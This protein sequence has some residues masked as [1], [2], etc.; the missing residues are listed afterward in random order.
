MVRLTPMTQE[1]FAAFLERDIRDYADEQV[2][3]GYWSRPEALRRSRQEHTRL[4]PDGLRTRDHHL[5]AIEDA[6]TD[7]PVGVLWLNSRLVSS[8]PSGFIYAIEVNEPLRRKGYARQAMLELEEV[9]RGMGL[10]QLALHVFAHN[11]A[12]R[13]LYEKLGYGITSL[14]LSKEL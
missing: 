1:Q 9:A 2:R 5:F 7:Q 6:E 4:L 10:K 8:R 13:A 14:N 12:A 3:A 11:D